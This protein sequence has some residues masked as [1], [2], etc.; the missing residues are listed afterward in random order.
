MLGEVK[1]IGFDLGYTLAF[2][3]R[4]DTYLAFAKEN[5]TELRRREVEI[6]FHLA[7]K[8]FMRQYPG[9]LGKRAETY[10]PWYLGVV[11]YHLQC[12]FDIE[13]QYEFFKSQRKGWS[14]FPWSQTV[15]EELQNKG[16]RLAL[17]S[18][19]DES[20]RDV[21]SQLSL[22]RYFEEIIVS[23]EQGI[24]KPDPRIF[25][26]LIEKMNC[27]PEELLYVGDNYYDDV[28]GSKKIGAQSILINRFGRLGIEELGSIPV[29]EKTDSLV[30]L[31]Q[32]GEIL[33]DISYSR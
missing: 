30:S 24:E 10:F 16:Y 11:N 28:V 21:L 8:T 19:W 12:R 22:D 1:V 20:C 2:N 15:L 31:L 9:A 7:D 29:I 13:R 5:K 3:H 17:L 27:K 25:T 33:H 18:N 26:S 6:A 32:E 14:P 4:E 23:S